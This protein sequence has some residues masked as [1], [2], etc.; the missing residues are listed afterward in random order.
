M[1]PS[2]LTVGAPPVSI[3]VVL[4][5]QRIRTLWE[6]PGLGGGNALT[7][8]CFALFIMCSHHRVPCGRHHLECVVLLLERISHESPCGRIVDDL[9]ATSSVDSVRFVVPRKWAVPG[10]SHDR[11]LDVVFIPGQ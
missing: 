5:R 1:E 6:F 10:D 9:V 8:N 11:V 3:N 4:L 2:P 7:S